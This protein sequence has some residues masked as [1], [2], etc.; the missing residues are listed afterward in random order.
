MS[1]GGQLALWLPDAQVMR[2]DCHRRSMCLRLAPA[3]ARFSGSSSLAFDVG[4]YGRGWVNTYTT[5]N[6]GE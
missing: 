6:E 5:T 1:V 2:T 4:N 3:R